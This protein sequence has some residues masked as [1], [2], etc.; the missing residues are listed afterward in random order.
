ME[1]NAVLEARSR[2][3][4]RVRKLDTDLFMME[5]RPPQV[6]HLHAG[7]AV[8]GFFVAFEAAVALLSGYEPAASVAAIGLR[9]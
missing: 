6:A 3:F 2:P 4:Y 5:K 1:R 9:G 8:V 7:G